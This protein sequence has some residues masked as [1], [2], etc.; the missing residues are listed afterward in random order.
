MV[1][2]AQRLQFAWFFAETP[3]LTA[4]EAMTKLLG[5]NADQMETNRV[6]SP[7]KPFL[8]SATCSEQ[9]HE[10]RLNISTGRAD[11]FVKCSPSV[12][13]S[14]YSMPLVEVGAVAKSILERFRQGDIN[15][16]G[17]V[18]RAAMVA[19]FLTICKSLDDAQNM[20]FDRVGIGKF[21]GPISDLSFSFNKRKAAPDGLASLNRIINYSVTQFQNLQIDIGLGKIEANDAVNSVFGFEMTIDINSVPA[22]GMIPCDKLLQLYEEIY[23]EMEKASAIALPQELV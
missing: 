12:G 4:D 20:F 11:L 7:Q 21:S 17:E 18:Y 9:E 22:A 15:C 16:F 2:T 10:Y 23:N 6:P 13:Q 19:P 1:N 5:L 14:V 8:S 3:D